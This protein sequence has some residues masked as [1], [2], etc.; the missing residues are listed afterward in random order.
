MS[1]SE[2][3]AF[4]GGGNMADS[5]IGGLLAGGHPAQA[6]RVAEPA[7]EQRNR[8]ARRHGIAT[9]ADNPSAARGA[10]VVVL[11]V[12]PQ[13][14]AGV[15]RDLGPTLADEAPLFVSV[16]A[17]VREADIARWLGGSPALVRVMPNTP[18]L[19]GAGACALHASAGVT[20]GQ[21]ELAERLA[22]AAGLAVWLDDE[23]QMDIVTAL[24]GSG[25]A[26][27]F[28]IMEALTDAAAELGLDRE[29]AAALCRQTALGAALMARDA[30]ED[31]ATLRRRVT[32]PGGTTEQGLAALEGDGLRDALR[33]AVSAAHERAGELADDLGRQ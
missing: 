5:L 28:L 23:S 25:P 14:L 18:A 16:A 3:F 20:A 15:C 4:V 17:G 7:A 26:Y 31:F 22:S 8:L 27:F 9:T 19:L 12:K 1:R 29:T 24:S 11:A 10:D 21:R 6:I 33:R 13:V 30:D 32:S 2:T